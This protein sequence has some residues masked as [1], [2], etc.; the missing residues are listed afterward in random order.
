MLQQMHNPCCNSATITACKLCILILCIC[1]KE[2]MVTKG[3][4]WIVAATQP[5]E[6]HVIPSLMPTLTITRP[7]LSLARR[8]LPCAGKLTMY[9]TTQCV[10]VPLQLKLYNCCTEGS[11]S[12]FPA[13]GNPFMPASAVDSQSSEPS[14]ADN[15]FTLMLFDN[16]GP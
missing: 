6:C 14:A 5:A 10:V 2:H 7:V 12:F 1:R 8:V 15:S 16:I 3:P 4:I 9:D 11:L 13:A